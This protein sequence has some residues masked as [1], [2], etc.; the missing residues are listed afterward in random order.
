MIFAI[1][2]GGKDPTAPRVHSPTPAASSPQSATISTGRVS[3][4]LYEILI[5]TGMLEAEVVPLRGAE[6]HYNVLH[7]LEGW[8]CTKCVYVTD[9]EW[10]GKNT[11]LVDVGIRH[12]YPSNRLDLTGRDVR[13]IAIF[14]GATPFPNHTVR[15]RDG[16]PQPLLASR[17][18]I[19][20]DGYTTHFNRWTAY[21]GKEL[22]D[23]RR[24]RLTPPS[25]I[26][27][28]GNLHPFK[29]FYTHE[30][31]RMFYPDSSDVRTYELNVPKQTFIN[32]AY[33]V[34]ASWSL[35]LAWPVVDPIT[36]FPLSASSRE[37]YQISMSIDDNTLTQQG[38][39]ADLTLE[40][41]DHQGIDTIASIEIEAPDLFYGVQYVDPS[42]PAYVSGDMAGYEVT[43]SNTTGYAKTA[44]GG[45]DILVVVEDVDMSVVGE[46][47]RAYNVFTLPVE[48][49][50]RKWRPRR[51]TFLD[52]PFPGPAP[53]GTRVDMTVVRNPQAPWAF[54]PGEPMLVFNDDSGSRYISYNRDFDQWSVLAGYPGMPNSWLKP[55]TR[56][57]A[58]GTGTFGVLSGSDT[59][60]SGEYLVRHCTNM[61]SQGGLYFYS[62]FTGSLGD[63]SPYLEKGGD[64]SGGFGNA[65]GDPVYTM[66]IFDS[67]AGYPP[68]L[69]QSIHRIALPYDDAHEV[70][71]AILPLIDTLSGNM[72]PY[73]ISS[74]FFVALGVDDEPVGELNPFTVHVYTAENRPITPLTSDRELDLFR[75]DFSD[76]LSYQH[77]RTFG[78]LLLGR[79]VVGPVGEQPR[80]VDVDVL[81]AGVDHVYTGPGAYAEHNWIAA[82]FTF[83]TPFWHIEIFDALADD[84]DWQT[85]IYV[86]GP[87]MGRALAMDVDPENF[88]IYVLTDDGPA[89]SGALNLSCLE[90]Y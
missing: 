71:R 46:D 23:Y 81:P 83:N 42:S 47:V 41:F 48:E 55:T 28:A 84:P 18:M 7:M 19:N 21:E 9:M 67:T 34:D 32:F 64:V 15:D 49:V 51:G 90:Y 26:D 50:A 61:H 11:L 2:C 59:P 68:P 1:G 76:P 44:D 89:G 40:V 72:P 43:I 79:G 52:Q 16:N 14:N 69:Y 30:V 60:V 10:S 17:T 74:T 80:I 62:W 8:A 82:L 63:A 86:I 58:A 27:L 13:G 77:I 4:G 24:G 85:P 39:H 73:G 37:A 25:E 22:F 36:Q 12:P 57:D 53:D 65:M 87:Y 5:D 35:P 78:N 33:S 66:Y 20:P 3:W 31:L 38:G 6:F 56:L 75:V 70:L 54:T 88:E 29:C 45:S